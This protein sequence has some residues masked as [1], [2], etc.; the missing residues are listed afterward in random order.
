MRSIAMVQI[1]YINNKTLYNK[2][3]TQIFT[4]TQIFNYILS[5]RV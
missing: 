2:L 1:A 5:V 3:S 4:H